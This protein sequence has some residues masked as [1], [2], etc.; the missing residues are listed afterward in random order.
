MFQQPTDA[1]IK[2]KPY[3][4]LVTGATGFIVTRLILHL[5]IWIFCKGN[6]QKNNSRTSNVKYVQANVSDVIQ[7][8]NI[9]TGVRLRVICFIP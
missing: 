5:Q 4:I 6:I 3:S 2:N 8:E 1:C 9:L 7:L